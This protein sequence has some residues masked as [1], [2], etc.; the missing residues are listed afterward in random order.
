[1]SYKGLVFAASALAA[2][3]AST[4]ASADYYYSGYDYGSRTYNSGYGSARPAFWGY[5]ALDLSHG[6]TRVLATYDEIQ[7]TREYNDWRYGPFRGNSYGPDRGVNDYGR[8]YLPPYLLTGYRDY[9]WR[10]YGPEYDNAG[11]GPDEEDAPYYGGEDRER[12]YGRGSYDYS[13]GQDYG[14]DYGRGSYGYSYYR[15][16]YRD[17]PRYSSAY[18]RERE[19]EHGWGGYRER[20]YEQ[21]WSEYRRPGYTSGWSYSRGTSYGSGW[22]D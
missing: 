7:A 18:Y 5:P 8:N 20:R 16:S 10:D 21:G 1:M 4:A 11:Y 15:P 9:D 12:Y 6:N 3:F 2:L 22:G 14:R 19:Y 13:Y 17:E